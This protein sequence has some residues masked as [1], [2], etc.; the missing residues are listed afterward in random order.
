MPKIRERERE[1]EREM[2]SEETLCCRQS[3]VYNKMVPIFNLEY[4]I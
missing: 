4:L 1:R 2:A 3:F